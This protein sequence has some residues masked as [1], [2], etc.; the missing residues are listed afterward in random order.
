MQS[1]ITYP[2][3]PETG[4]DRLQKEIQDRLDDLTKPKGSLGRLEECAARFMQCRGSATARLDRMQLFTFAADHGVAARGITPYP[5]EVTSQMVLN[6]LGG[7]AAVSVMCAT[8]G[9]DWRVVDMGVVAELPAHP[10]LLDR[11]SPR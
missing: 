5:Q 10:G 3:I 6:M 8:A 2:S 9:I 4:N 7:G 1:K 11:K